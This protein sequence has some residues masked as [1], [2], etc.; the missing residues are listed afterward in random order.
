[1][2]VIP[3]YLCKE[4]HMLKIKR[5]TIIV[6][7]I[8]LI[9][10]LIIVVF[11]SFNGTKKVNISDIFK[12]EVLGTDGYGYVNIAID[13]NFIEAT[14]VNLNDIE[15]TVNKNSNLSNGDLICI[16]V[17]DIKGVKLDKNQFEYEISG[18]NK[19]TDLDIF[20]DLN[21]E[22]DVQNK[23]IVLD[24]SQCSEFIK[25]NV[26]FSIKY[27]KDEYNLGDA[28][29]I[30]GYVDMNAAADNGYNVVSTIL[31]YVVK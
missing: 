7:A 5:N 12:I 29:T 14:G 10:L 27:E 11:K 16:T 23:K 2:G 17:S 4:Y 25:K 28:V 13:M 31:E 19:A 9:I 8:I 15:Y 18:L 24:N 6:T 26:I 22:Y 20:K 21:V 30:V 3:K 1:M